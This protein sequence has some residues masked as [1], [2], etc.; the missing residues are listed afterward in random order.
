M[1]LHRLRRNPVR[2]VPRTLL[3]T[4]PFR[5]LDREAQAL[6]HHIGVQDHP[7]IHIARRP[8][9]RLHQRCLGPQEPLLVGIQNRHQRA[10][11]NIQPFAQQINPYQHIIHAKPQIADNLDPLQRIHIRM[12]VAHLHALLG[13]I[14]GQILRHAF[15]KCRHQNA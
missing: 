12:Q 7:P 4:A 10:F 3:V 13:E 14:F 5:L 6:R 2:L 9:D 8:A 1:L 11:G 15:C